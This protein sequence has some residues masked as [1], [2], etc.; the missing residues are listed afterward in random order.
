MND[1]LKARKPMS[2]AIALSLVFI[3]IAGCDMPKTKQP[4]WTKYKYYFDDEKTGGAPGGLAL[5][6]ASK[7]GSSPVTL[8][9]G[10]GIE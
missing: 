9:M 6:K 3:A 7:D 4:E 10:E 2:A 5:R 8:D 1:L